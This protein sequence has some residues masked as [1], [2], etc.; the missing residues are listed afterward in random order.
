MA[1]YD[2]Q[3]RRQRATPGAAGPAAVDGLLEPSDPPARTLGADQ[4]T[5]SVTAPVT[6]TPTV[7][8]VPDPDEA[9]EAVPAVEPVT[10]APVATRAGSPVLAA[11]VAA[12]LVLLAALVVRRRLRR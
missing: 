4:A 7:T 12:V 11:A 10:A 3:R 2:P 9:P 6:A 1:G 5:T 8:L